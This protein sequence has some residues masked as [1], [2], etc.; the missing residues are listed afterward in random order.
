MTIEQTR[1]EI[2]YNKQVDRQILQIR[3][4]TEADIL[5]LEQTKIEI[6]EVEERKIG[7]CDWHRTTKWYKDGMTDEE[8]IERHDRLWEEYDKLSST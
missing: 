8:I 6:D 5:E 4:D 3:T 7:L 2:E 1:E